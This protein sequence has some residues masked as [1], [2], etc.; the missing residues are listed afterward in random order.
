[1]SYIEQLNEVHVSHAL[2]HH[3]PHG[4]REHRVHHLPIGEKLSC[5][6]LESPREF[7]GVAYVMIVKSHCSCMRPLAADTQFPR[8]LFKSN[9][10]MSKPSYRQIQWL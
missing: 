7:L 8:Q 5:L 10:Q 6:M 1:M 4:L 2:V 9:W 3:I